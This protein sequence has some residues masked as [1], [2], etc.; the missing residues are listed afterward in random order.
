M[1]VVPPKY[2]SFSAT[3][4]LNPCAA[5]FNAAAIPA[6]P[7]PMTRTSQAAVFAVS[8]MVPAPFCLRRD[9]FAA[10]GFD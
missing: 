4:T 10:A 5:A 9:S 1:A 7:D 3:I 8:V 6:T 2:C